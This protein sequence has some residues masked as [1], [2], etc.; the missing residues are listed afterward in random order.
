MSNMGIGQIFSR[1]LDGLN[2]NQRGLAATSNNIANMNTKGYSRQE[3]VITAN[4]AAQG[5]ARVEAVEAITSPFVE[6]Q[7]FNSMNDFG[8]V[9]G[10]RRTVGQ[11]E[12][13]FN[14]SAD[15][16]LAKQMNE[17]FGSFAALSVDPSS[18]VLRQDVRDRAVAVSQ[19]FNS[20]YEQVNQM[21]GDISLD[22]STKVDRVNALASQIAQINEQLVGNTNEQQTLDLK[23]QRLSLLKDLSTEVNC[24]YFE[25]DGTMQVA[26]NGSLS[27]VNGKNAG[28]L[29]LSNDLSTGGIMT[30]NLKLPG[31]PSASTL[32]ITTQVTGGRLGGAL[33]DRNTTLND[34]MDELDELAY[35]LVTEVNSLH[36]AG[37]GLDGTTG[38]NF[39][40]PLA[41]QSGA[42]RNMAV[43][44]TILNDLRRIA[45]AEQDPAVSG[46]GDNRTALRLSELQNEKTMTSGSQTFLQFYQGMVGSIGVTA[47]QVNR[48]FEIQ[49]NLVNQLEIQRESVSGVNLDEEG[50]NIIR[51]QRA[52]QA[53]SKLIMTADE[54]LETLMGIK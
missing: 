8:T 1:G 49:A 34:R 19:R 51:Y 12:A 11:I 36:S 44:S 18:S 21:R 20:L 37:Y 53:S 33:L 5:G 7:L 23:G 43:D 10:R 31:G 22:I 14:E 50:A 27:L 42:A 32:N 38:V 17:F 54:M 26:I 45:A 35:N 48:D 30:V 40:A 29:S 41:S 47:G 15:N 24:S 6:L 46:V 2:V 9:D 4:I 25:Q 39:F 16:G 3:V 52:F 28:T 13:M